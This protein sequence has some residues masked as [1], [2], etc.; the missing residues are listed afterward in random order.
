MKGFLFGV[1]FGLVGFFAILGYGIMQPLAIAARSKLSGGYGCT[2]SCVWDFFLPYTRH[3]LP[4]V[5]VLQE[6]DAK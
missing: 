4:C 2:S 6:K 5:Q 1:S 3:V